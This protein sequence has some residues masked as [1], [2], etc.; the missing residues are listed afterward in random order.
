MDS[1]NPNPEIIQKISTNQGSNNDDLIGEIVLKELE[2]IDVTPNTKHLYVLLCQC[3]LVDK[4]NYFVEED[5]DDQVLSKL[6][7]NGKNFTLLTAKLH[8]NLGSTIKFQEA[9]TAFQKE[10]RTLEKEETIGQ[11]VKNKVET[12]YYK[13]FNHHLVSIFV[14]RNQIL[15]GLNETP[16]KRKSEFKNC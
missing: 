10:M 11:G 4:F 8:L 14:C 2:T 9:L 12:K 5:V 13:A 15:S 6:D 16:S 7:P 3:N 1:N